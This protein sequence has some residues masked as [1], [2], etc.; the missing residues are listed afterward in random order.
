MYDV[1]LP[2]P[3]TRDV[4][5]PIGF[6]VMVEVRPS[7]RSVVHHAIVVM[8]NGTG[9]R[10]QEYLAGYAPPAEKFGEKLVPSGSEVSS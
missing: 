7:D 8:D 2:L 1:V 6:H 10:G 3:S 4:T 9:F 5:W